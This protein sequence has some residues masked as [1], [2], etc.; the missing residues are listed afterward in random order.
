MPTPAAKGLPDIFV[1]EINLI[2]FCRRIP[3]AQHAFGGVDEEPF[4][5][6]AGIGPFALQEIARE[7]H[8][9]GDVMAE[10]PNAS[11]GLGG[12]HFAVTARSRFHGVI[13]QHLIDCKA[14]PIQGFQ[15]VRGGLQHECGIFRMRWIRKGFQGRVRQEASA[16]RR[17]N[18]QW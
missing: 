8:R 16:T 11:A 5:L 14:K 6:R 18:K 7:P 9:I 12:K 13:K 2:F 10:I 3:K 15:R 1:R 17:R 4:G